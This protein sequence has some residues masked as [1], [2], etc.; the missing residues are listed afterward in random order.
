MP[1]LPK[2]LARTECSKG[3]KLTPEN[4]TKDNRCKTCMRS[5]PSRKPRGTQ[6]REKTHCP[7]GHPYEGD[8]L[9]VYKRGKYEIRSCRACKALRAR[10]YYRDIIKPEFHPGPP[11]RPRKYDRDGNIL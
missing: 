11:G 10:A 4:R 8:N 7:H 9:S 1:R 2:H 6:N 3:H 5:M